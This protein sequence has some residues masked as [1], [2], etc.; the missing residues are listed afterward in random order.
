MTT[1]HLTET[2]EGL[3]RAILEVA[4]GGSGGGE[5]ARRGRNDNGRRG[6]LGNGG[7]KVSVVRD[8]GGEKIKSLI[9]TV[10]KV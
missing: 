8:E 7:G 3:A 1:A 4:A 10:P 5:R 9:V 2:G 6:S